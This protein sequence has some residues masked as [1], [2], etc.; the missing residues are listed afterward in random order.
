MPITKTFVP[1]AIDVDGTLIDQIQNYVASGGLDQILLGGDGN[2]FNSFVATATKRQGATFDTTGIAKALDVAAFTGKKITSGTVITM[3]FQKTAGGSTR[4]GATSHVKLIMNEGLLMPTGLTVTNDQPAILSF[5][6]IATHDG[7]NEPLAVTINQSLIGTPSIDQAFTV[8]PIKLNGTTITEIQSMDMDFGINAQILG[9]DGEGEVT[10]VYITRIQ[11]RIRAV[12]LD[13]ETVLN[14]FGFGAIAQSATPGEES[15]AYLRKFDEGSS[16]VADGTAEHI[17]FL[18]H[19]GQIHTSEG[20]ATEDGEAT[21][22]LVMT[23]TWDGINDP[24][25]LDTSVAIT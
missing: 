14:T 2:I 17:S 21:A 19:Q 7:A 24:F 22:T 18:Q 25:L 3:F 4:S 11:P 15:V 16:R 9:G 20:S 12:T 10:Y 6:A 1:Y 23:P 5:T 8:G 13:V